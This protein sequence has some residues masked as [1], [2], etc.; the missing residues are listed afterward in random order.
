[1]V[2]SKVK[3]EPKYRR[4]LNNEQLLVL[5][6]LYNY[7]FST[8]EYITKYLDKTDIKVVQKKLKI[9]EDQGYIAK[10]YDKSYKLHGRP[11]EYYQTPKGARLLKNKPEIKNIS[12]QGIKNLYRNPTASGDFMAHSLN[13]LK[14]VLHLRT[15][16]GDKIHAF[17]RNELIPYGYFPEWRPDLY[18]NLIVKGETEPAR[19]FLDIW[20]GSRPFFVSVRKARSY[21]TYLEDGDWPTDREFP[22]ILMLCDSE[23]NEIKLRRQIRKALDES[24]EDV[25][26]ATATIE[27]FSNTQKPTDKPWFTVFEDTDLEERHSLVSLLKSLEQSD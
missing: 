18:L 27:L 19:L 16:Y 22:V 21:I 11:A 23:K 5:K 7:R 15:I 13:I 25:Y 20:D 24:N 10:R 2:V 1:M 6:L 4:P 12:D 14:V 17:P 3:S 26:F 9:L 8:N